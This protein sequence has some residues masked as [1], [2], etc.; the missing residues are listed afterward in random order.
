MNE[1]CAAAERYGLDQLPYVVTGLMHAAIITFIVGLDISSN[2]IDSPFGVAANVA[3]FFTITVY[4]ITSVL[5]LWDD[6]SPYRT[7]LTSLIKKLTRSSRSR[8]RRE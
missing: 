8:S 3:T 6:D 2:S 7:P 4:V 1:L 5:A